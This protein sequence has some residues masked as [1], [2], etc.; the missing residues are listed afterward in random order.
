MRPAG[1]VLL[2]FGWVAA[3]PAHGADRPADRILDEI[4]A[5]EMPR[6]TPQVRSDPDARDKFLAARLK[7]LTR[8][9]ELTRE[10]FKADP[11]NPKLTMLL[12]ER[13]QTLLSSSEPKSLRSLPAEIDEVTSKTKSERLKTEGAFW[14]AVVVLVS[15]EGDAET[16]LR[17]ADAFIHRA[18]KDERGSLL[19]YQ[20][21]MKNGLSPEEKVAIYK[22]LIADYPDTQYASMA[23]G[24]LKRAE[25]IGKPFELE[26]TDAIKGT[27]VSIKDLKGKVVVI[28]FWATWCGPC[29]G[30]M[31]K[32]KKL[33]AKYK[34]K[35][36]EFI[37]VSLD[38]SKEE[39]GLDK[40][41]E[42]VAKNDITWPQYYQGQGWDSKFSTSLGITAIPCIFVVDADGKLSATD[43]GENLEPTI[44]K[45]LK[46]A[47]GK[48]EAGAGGG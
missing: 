40:L 46:K 25:K 3:A 31:P 39:G 7:A 33:Y 6:L 45:L 47:G 22:R 4:T 38:E 42:F 1:L 23:E 19:L 26:F 10:L 36:V 41:K 16:G 24:S 17:A 20:A 8:R 44:A 2:A 18:P 43:V 29:V 14:K 30:A 27:N 37:G 21:A 28:D 12:P 5:V 9:A 48:H 32:M 35:G 13:W 15:E 34:D 11:E